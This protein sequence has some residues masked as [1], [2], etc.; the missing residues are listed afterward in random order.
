MIHDRKAQDICELDVD[1]VP[2]RFSKAPKGIK[3]STRIFHA[4]LLSYE[5]SWET[6]VALR[7]ARTSAAKET[8]LLTWSRFL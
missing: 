3:V 8:S 4:L 5:N 2:M 7:T 6:T 1:W